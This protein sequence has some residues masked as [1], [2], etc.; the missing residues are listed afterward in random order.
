M[1]II[2]FDVKSRNRMQMLKWL[3]EIDGVDGVEGFD[4]YRAFLKSASHS[5]PDFCL[6]RLGEDEIPGLKAGT[7]IGELDHSIKTV[8]MCENESYAVD[9]FEAG[10][11]GYLL[12]PVSRGKF[13]KII[14]ARR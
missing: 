1:R 14:M 4:E 12:Y 3:S 10:A 7:R 13:E 11:F 2:V 5:P 8:Y 6:I 9:A